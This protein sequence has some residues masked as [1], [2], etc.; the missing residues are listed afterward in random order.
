MRPAKS[1]P[2][3]LDALMSEPMDEEDEEMGESPD[4]A[5]MV[6][7]DEEPAAPEEGTPEAE[8]EQIRGA[9]DRLEMMFLR[10]QG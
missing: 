7:E 4:V 1:K 2:D 9:L 10:K 3:V 6:T 5:V 8:L